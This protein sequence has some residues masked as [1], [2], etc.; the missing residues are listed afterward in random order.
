MKTQIEHVISLLQHLI[1]QYADFERL[2]RE[3]IDERD[4]AKR[5]FA[6][7]D[8][9]R[10]HAQA[11]STQ[12]VEGKRALLARIQPKEIGRCP[13][14]QHDQWSRC[15]EGDHGSIPLTASNG[16]TWWR[17]TYCKTY[18]ALEAAEGK[19]DIILRATR[20]EPDDELAADYGG[21]GWENDPA[22]RG[23]Y[24]LLAAI[25]KKEDLK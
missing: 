22:V 1:Q 14:C 13:T 2:W 12:L 15:Q 19:L 21:T 10:R 18:A 17:C 20:G 7:A 6:E 4:E 23:V 5:R 9:A 16:V 11:V 24:A 3:A 25:P 8:A